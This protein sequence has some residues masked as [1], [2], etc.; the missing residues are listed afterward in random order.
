MILLAFDID[1]GL[2]S[3]LTFKFLVDSK[4]LSFSIFPHFFGFSLLPSNFCLLVDLFPL[5]L[6]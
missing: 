3:L 5:V 4:R 2:F 1:L 6:V